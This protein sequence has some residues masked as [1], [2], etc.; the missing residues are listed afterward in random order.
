MSYNLLNFNYSST[1]RIE[2]YNTVLDSLNPDILV[3]QEII[4]QSA[5]NVFLSEVLDATYAAGEF[6]DGPD[7][8]NAVFYKAGKFSFISNIPIPTA[9]RDINEFKLEHGDTYDT[10]RIY[11]VHLKASSGSTN[12]NKRLQETLELRNVTDGLPTDA[13]F[14]VCGDFNIYKSSEPAYIKLTTDESINDGH[15]VDPISI[16]GTWNNA[17]FA[18]Y[19]T[20]STRTRQF[21]GG[22]SGG[23]DDRFDMILFSQAIAND[24][25]MSYV[26]NSTLAV[27]N[28][29]THYNDSI[30]HPPNNMVSQEFADALYYASDHLPVTAEFTFEIQTDVYDLA[31]AQKEIVFPNPIKEVLNVNLGEDHP[32]IVKILSTNGNTIFNKTFNSSHQTIHLND[33][34]PGV[35]FLRIV[36]DGRVINRRIVK[37]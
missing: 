25:G 6:I 11:S 27:G 31:N 4:S 23:L 1:D 32:F 7:S 14:I 34:K 10:L 33:V 36:V 9:L 8:D 22:A 5:V 18:A 15:A 21:G 37:L 28:D 20:Q 12:E 29:G 17:S 2:H 13:Y 24:G 19:H 16:S 35:Y 26:S 3:V 30:N